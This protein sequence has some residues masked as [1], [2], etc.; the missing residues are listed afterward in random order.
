MFADYLFLFISNGIISLYINEKKKKYSKSGKKI[1][2]VF[3]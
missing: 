1:Y 2:I 3:I